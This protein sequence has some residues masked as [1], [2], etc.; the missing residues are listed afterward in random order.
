MCLLFAAI[1]FLSDHLLWGKLAA[2]LNFSFHIL[3]FSPLVV[4]FD[5]YIFHFFSHYVCF[6]L[7][8]PI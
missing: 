3:Y 8:I 1:F 4:L 2:M 5:P 6:P 7:N